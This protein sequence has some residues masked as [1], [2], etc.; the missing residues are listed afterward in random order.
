MKRVTMKYSPRIPLAS[1][2]NKKAAAGECIGETKME[3]ALLTQPVKKNCHSGR[4]VTSNFNN[5]V[6]LQICHQGGR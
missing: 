6:E 2:K 4:D 3:F 1:S 5:N